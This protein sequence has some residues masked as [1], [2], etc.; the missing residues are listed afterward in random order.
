[1]SDGTETE[2]PMSE[3]ATEAPAQAAA[4]VGEQPVAEAP[5]KSFT[6]A[7]LD[8]VVADRLKRE[9]EKFGD[10]DDLKEKAEKYDAAEEAAKTEA[11]RAA[12]AAANREREN[13]A[14]RLDNARLRAATAHSISGEDE[15]GVPYAD[16]IAG[17]DDDSILRSAQ[18]IG[19]LV[20]A[21]RELAQIKAQADQPTPPSNGRPQAALRPGATPVETPLEDDAYPAGWIPQR[22]T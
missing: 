15:D 5:E 13:D 8:R 10:Y 18:A 2:K 3:N 19:R 16:L 9:R 20:A 14:L 1:M 7:D 17:S 22:A 6:Q 4:E 12:E 21:S 11:Q